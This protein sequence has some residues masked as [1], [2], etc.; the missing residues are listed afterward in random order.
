[1]LDFIFLNF[2]VILLEH[3]I[4]YE[5]FPPSVLSCLPKI[6]WSPYPLSPDQREDLTHL[7]ICSVDPE[8][9]LFQKYLKSKKLTGCT[10]IDDALHCRELNSGKFEVGVHIADGTELGNK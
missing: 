4:P 7:E 3:D 5:E 6:P 8:G 9:Y 1:M 10:D 2:Q